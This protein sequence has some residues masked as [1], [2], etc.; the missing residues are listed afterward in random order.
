MTTPQDYRTLVTR[1]EAIQEGAL[2]GLAGDAVDAAK[3]VGVAPGAA[4]AMLRALLTSGQS[5]LPE[6]IM[7]L[8]KNKSQLSPKCQGVL[9]QIAPGT[10]D[11]PTRPAQG[12]GPIRGQ[13]PMPANPPV[14]IPGQSV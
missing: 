1:L 11:Q 9:N 5:V 13:G 2:A 3:D 12:T 14:L 8:M 7:F 6:I 4:G 10:G